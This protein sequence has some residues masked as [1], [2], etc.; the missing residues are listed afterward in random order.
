M[1]QYLVTEKT[2]TKFFSPIRTERT[3]GF[4]LR[5]FHSRPLW[6]ACV[7]RLFVRGPSKGNHLSFNNGRSSPAMQVASGPLPIPFPHYIFHLAKSERC[8]ARMI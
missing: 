8:K 7:L 4:A 1:N 6:A 5:R 2:F 3:N